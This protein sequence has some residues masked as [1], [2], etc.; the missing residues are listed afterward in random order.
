MYSV[1]TFP[2]LASYVRLQRYCY[3]D[4]SATTISGPTEARLQC[5]AQAIRTRRGRWR[6]TSATTLSTAVP[7]D[8]AGVL[9]PFV[10]ASA[11][12]VAAGGSP[13][14]AATPWCLLTSAWHACRCAT[15]VSRLFF[16]CSSRMSRK[17][18]WG[19]ARGR[20]S[21]ARIAYLNSRN[22]CHISSP[23]TYQSVYCGVE[24]A[25]CISVHARCTEVPFK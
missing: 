3:N 5:S 19:C 7:R 8:S 14:A 18:V 6:R 10:E 22:K 15:M 12:A 9:L 2:P 16:Q 21:G 23:K 24:Q 20:S 17:G 4:Y 25:R 11:G 13:R 1:S